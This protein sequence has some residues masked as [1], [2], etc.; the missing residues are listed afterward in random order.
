[1]DMYFLKFP[2]RKVLLPIAK[3]LTFINPD[4]ISYAATAVAFITMFCYVFADKNPI[5]LIIAILLTFTRMTFNTI[6]GVIAIER[7]NLRLK[8]EIVNALPDRYSDAF[9]MCGLVLCPYSHPIL[10]L[11]ALSTAFLVS[12][13]GML[14]KALGVE[15]QHQGPVDK[16][17]RLCLIMLFSF[18]Q[19]LNL[20]GKIPT[21]S[22]FNH[23]L[24]YLEICMV[25]VGIFGQVTVINRLKG[26]LKQIK[27]L[28]REKY[29]NL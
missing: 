18:L 17:A 20:T 26:Q 15:W 25:I 12:Y 22:M 9:I 14:G 8:G 29:K 5:L 2:Y 1:M 13:T 27:E 7:G 6:D 3:K 4:I 24:S 21:I 10:G 23:N 19:Y 28:E 11:I 16:V